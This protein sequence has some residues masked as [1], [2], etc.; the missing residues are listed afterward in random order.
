MTKYVNL[1]LLAAL[2]ILSCSSCCRKVENTTE[3]KNYY[4]YIRQETGVLPTTIVEFADLSDRKAGLCF[5]SRNLIKF[6][7]TYWS[8]SDD[9][10]KKAL[11]LHEI[12]HC[13]FSLPHTNSGIMYPIVLS[14]AEFKANEA[15]LLQE[16]KSQI[17]AQHGKKL[18]YGHE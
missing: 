11:L 18:P 15:E 3:I 10:A 1:T 17:E 7:R 9:A 6:D 4:N 12:G 16:W 14:S 5:R 2:L 8:K 13:V